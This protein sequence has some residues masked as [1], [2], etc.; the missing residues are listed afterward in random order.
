MNGKFS[1][2]VA[3]DDVGGIGKNGMLPWRIPG[4]LQHFKALTTCAPEGKQNAII[5]GR[6]TWE[7]LPLRPLPGRLN[8]IVST[9]MSGDNVFPTFNNALNFI[10]GKCDC[11]HKIFIIGG[12]KMY[13][14]A[15]LHPNCSSVFVTRVRG[16]FDC[17]TYFP[18]PIMETKYCLVNEG[19]IQCCFAGSQTI[20]YCFQEYL[21]DRDGKFDRCI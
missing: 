1:I 5:M 10:T 8:L 12:Q 2:V 13:E 16:T 4:D 21:R 9:T 3:Y 6:K 17:D 15:L 19:S 7:S 18:I 20:C 11:V 14:E